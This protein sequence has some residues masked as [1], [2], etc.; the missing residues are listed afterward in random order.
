MV[1][2]RFKEQMISSFTRQPSGPDKHLLCIW[3]TIDKPDV[4][5]GLGKA[6]KRS[7]DLGAF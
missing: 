5:G 6:T 2:S 3:S 1:M 7:E 4:A